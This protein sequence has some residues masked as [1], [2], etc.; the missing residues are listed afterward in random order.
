MILEHAEYEDVPLDKEDEASP[1]T[2]EAQ[3][4]PGEMKDPTEVPPE[5]A[6]EA[7]AEATQPAPE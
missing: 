5:A 2:V 3:A 6:A 1:G 7:P 4:V